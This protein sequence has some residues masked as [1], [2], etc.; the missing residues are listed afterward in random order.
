M[1]TSAGL[2]SS[3]TARGRWLSSCSTRA[4]SVRLCRDRSVPFGKYCRRSPFVFS[5]V[6][7]CHGLPRTARVAEVNRGTGGGGDVE[8]AGHLAALV[9]GDRLQQPRGQAGQFTQQTIAQLHGVRARKTD[10]FDVA[11]VAFDERADRRA[12]LRADDDVTF[13]VTWLGAVLRRE[14]A[15][16]HAEHGFPEASPSPGEADVFASVIAAGAQ[17]GGRGATQQQAFGSIQLL[18]DSFRCEVPVRSSGNSRR[19]ARL[20]WAGLHRCARRSL[21]AASN[22]G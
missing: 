11:G 20:I 3:R 5:L 8:V 15:L 7:R 22:C 12:V 13:P 14:R 4:R 10:E 9:P 2:R 6:P 18:V 17:R 19:S 21:T 16:V 1:K